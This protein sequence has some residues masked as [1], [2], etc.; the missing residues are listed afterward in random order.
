MPPTIFQHPVNNLKT[1]LASAHSVSDGALVLSAGTGALLGSLAPNEIYRVTVL[2]NVGLSNES[3]AGI[4]EATTLATDTLSGLSFVEGFS[5]AAYASGLGVQVRPT[6]KEFASLHAAILA[7]QIVSETS[8]TGT[9]TLTSANLGLHHVASGTSANYAVTL[10][11]AVGVAGQRLWLRMSNALTK[12]VTVTGHAS[13]TIDGSNTRIMWAGEACE[14]IS[15]G[16]SWAKIAGKTIPMRAEL[17]LVG[18]GNVADSTVTTIPFDTTGFDNTGLMAG[19][20]TITAQRPGLYQVGGVFGLIAITA[21]A[22]RV[23]G[24][25]T[26][27]AS[28]TRGTVEFSSVSG[29]YP[30]V[31]ASITTTLAAGDAVTL[32]GFQNSLASQQLDNSG[33]GT[34]NWLEATEI[35]SW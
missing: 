19:G 6:A 33:S 10:P 17:H 16:S 2:N 13:E 4:V 21:S 14:L 5:D 20:H 12:L 32:A 34:T 15:D 29:A 25:I 28:V 9:T 1:T 23:F 11:T 8:I 35:P 31:F 22:V 30:T 27:N 26:V 18:T 24:Q 3:V 7:Q